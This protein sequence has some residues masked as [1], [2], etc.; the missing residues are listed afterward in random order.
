M[1]RRLEGRQLVLASGSPRRRE[2]LALLGVDFVVDLPCDVC[3]VYDPATPAEDV[4]LVLAGLKADAYRAAGC[5]AD[6]VVV[7]ADTVVIVYGC[8]LGKPADASG[9]RE[10]LRRL[11]GRSHRVVTGVV[12][13]SGDK[14]LRGSEI[15]EVEFDTLTDAE[16]DYY[17]DRYRPF[18]KAGAYGIQ[19][20]I[21]CIGIKG[22]RGDYYNVMGLPL[23]LLYGM[24]GNV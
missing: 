6:K 1:F 3:E 2:L 8:V 10:M 19:E 9:A 16:I 24:L 14:V 23:H 21:G 17:V 13:M 12:V 5:G 20:W 15:T 7:C 4:P 18:D 11:S 22:I